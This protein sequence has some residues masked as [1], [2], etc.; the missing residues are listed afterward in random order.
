MGPAGSGPPGTTAIMTSAGST[1]RTHLPPPEFADTSPPSNTSGC[2]FTLAEV[3]VQRPPPPPQHQPHSSFRTL[4]R[5]VNSIDAHNP[6][7]TQTLPLK[8]NLKKSTGSSSERSGG[9]SGG[10]G[11][12][13]ASGGSGA[14]PNKN[15]L[16]WSSDHHTG[17]T[18]TNHR[19]VSMEELR[20]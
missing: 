18:S 3:Q 12:V 16:Q 6:P 17:T 10:G 19:Q 7:N 9:S 8:S 15:T 4:P 14:N 11:V 20:V 5:P 13:S 1:F 2:H